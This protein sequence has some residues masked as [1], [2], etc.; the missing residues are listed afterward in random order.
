[1]M[2]SSFVVGEPTS[3][4]ESVCS[5]QYQQTYG[6]CSV[7]GVVSVLLRNCCSISGGTGRTYETMRVVALELAMSGC[8]VQAPS[9]PHHILHAQPAST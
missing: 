6:L 1:M 5:V 2:S 3:N 7:F 9:R 4:V 8:V